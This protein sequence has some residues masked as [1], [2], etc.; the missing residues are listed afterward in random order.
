MG[1]FFF[2]NS[3]ISLVNCLFLLTGLKSLVFDDC[4]KE[5]EWKV[6]FR[7]NFCKDIKELEQII[8]I[9]SI[10]QRSII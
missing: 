2:S 3:W 1:E 7:C 8:C 10:E 6:Q 9:T 4:R 5:E